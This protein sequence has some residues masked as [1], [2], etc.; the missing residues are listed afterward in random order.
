MAVSNAEET[1][2]YRSLKLLLL[3]A[4]LAG[5]LTGCIFV[6]GHRHHGYDRGPVYAPAPAPG[7]YRGY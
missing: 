5:P 7:Y 1:M 2:P 6:E 3:T 4:V